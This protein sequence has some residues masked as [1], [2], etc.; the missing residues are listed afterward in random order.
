MPIIGTC[1]CRSGSYVNEAC[2]TRPRSEA[3]YRHLMLGQGSSRDITQRQFAR[4]HIERLYIATYRAHTHVRMTVTEGKAIAGLISES[5]Q[6]IPAVPRQFTPNP[7]QL[8]YLRAWLDP[9]APKTVG[10]ICRHS[11]IPQRTVTHWL[12]Q[13]AFR[14]WFN[15]GIE[16][17]T[18]H[19]WQPLL[20]RLATLAMKGSVEHAKLLAQ[21]R[22][23]IRPVENG[24][25]AGVTVIVGV[26]R[27]GDHVAMPSD[28]FRPV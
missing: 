21:I 24:S 27:P 22:G 3:H 11:G 7:Q 5:S 19:L 15:A 10:A 17:A 23:A 2:P 1:A 16:R 18:D 4:S 9:G 12:A 6:R 25:G 14:R 13:D 8:R 26:P 20:L 28:A